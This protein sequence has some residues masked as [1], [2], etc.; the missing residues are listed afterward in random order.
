L[1]LLPG[2][3]YVRRLPGEGKGEMK[4]TVVR[5]RTTTYAVYVCMNSSCEDEEFAAQVPPI[6]V[7]LPACPC[8]GCPSLLL[9][10]LHR[11]N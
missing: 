3:Q 2:G 8:C 7:D 4:E 1:P 9:E 10:V 11:E 6:Y 5:T